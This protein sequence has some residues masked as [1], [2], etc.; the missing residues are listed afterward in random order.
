M[1]HAA[2]PRFWKAYA[3][4]PA[5]VRKLADANFALLKS[6]PTHPSLQF[7]KVGRFWSARVSLRYRALAVETNDA[8]VWFWIGSHADYDRLVG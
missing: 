2:S 5:N 7:K 4:L 6:D 1:K 8:Y 3:A